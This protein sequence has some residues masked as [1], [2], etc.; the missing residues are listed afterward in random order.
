VWP[1]PK[2]GKP[3]VLYPVE[4]DWAR[5]LEEEKSSL[6]S[7]VH[8]M[9]TE[10]LTTGEG[11]T[12][13]AQQLNEIQK[14]CQS[15]T[16][17]TLSQSQ[18]AAVQF[19]FQLLKKAE[20][21]V[22]ASY[23][24]YDHVFAA[25]SELQ[26]W[27]SL[28]PKHHDELIDVLF[29]I[30]S[31]M[32]AFRIEACRHPAKVQ[33]AVSTL[34]TD[35]KQMVKQVRAMLERQFEELSASEQIVRI[36]MEQVSTS[37]AQH[38]K[39]VASTL[40][41]SRNHL[42][43]LS[44]ALT[45]SGAGATYLV[46]QNQAVTRHIG[47]IVMAQQCQDITRQKIDHVGEAMDEMRNHLADARLATSAADADPRH[48]VFRAAQIQ[49]HQVQNVFD[50]LDRAARSLTSGIQSLRAEAGAAADMAVKVGG[51]ALDAK[52]ASQSNVSNGDVLAIMKQAV[53]KIAD[54]RAAFEPLRARFVNC[55]NKATELAGDVRCAALNAQLFA[56]NARNGGAL[57]ILAGLM[58]NISDKTI[59]QIGQMGAK[60]RRTDDMVND[61]QQRLTDFQDLGQTEQEVLINESALSQKKLS[62]LEGAIQDLIQSITRQQGTF[63]QSVDE[64]LANVQFPVAVAEASSRSVGFFRNLVA[65]GDD[66]GSE[67]VVESAASKKIDLLESN[68]T[69]ESERQAHRDALQPALTP[70]SAHSSQPSIE[71]FGE[72]ES[73]SSTLA[74]TLGDIALPSQRPEDQ[75]RPVRLPTD[76][77][78]PSEPPPPAASEKPVNSEG[79]GDNVEMF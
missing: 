51:T 45:S 21:L 35:V 52:M 67:F 8:G 44:E 40:E 12:R 46:R 9:E 43:A 16:D 22:L 7:L 15:L 24:Q 55:T 25:F 5:S 1:L 19:A 34:A 3:A 53:Q 2:A 70:S 32:T 36:L 60:L 63:A 48:F 33:E 62:D 54:V 6:F 30:N 49:L 23:D 72:S 65:W 4:A 14:D 76:N 39:K 75:P 27:L 66:G 26:R 18:D 59:K 28:L 57:E 17:L 64:V 31:I 50:E 79:L 69:M 42:R 68:Y 29:P 41:T 78:T 20:D 71:L 10:F 58:L 37:I 56:I 74:H 61:L 38:R 13:L 73:E 47:S 77:L 11:L